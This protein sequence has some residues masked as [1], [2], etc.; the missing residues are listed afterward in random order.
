M[1]DAK[2]YDELSRQIGMCIIERQQLSKKARA[3][4][5]QP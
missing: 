4:T 1:L 3:E 5:A 2:Y